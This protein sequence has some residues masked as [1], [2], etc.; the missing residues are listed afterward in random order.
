MP[1]RLSFLVLLRASLLVAAAGAL[2]AAIVW[3]LFRRLE[4]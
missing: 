2:F 1:R 4:L 3:Y